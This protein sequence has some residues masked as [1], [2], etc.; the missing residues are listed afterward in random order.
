MPSTSSNMLTA[1]GEYQYRFNRRFDLSRRLPRM[2]TA[3]AQTGKRTERW[4]SLAEN[5]SK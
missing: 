2:I 1:I 5:Q 3:E 4:L